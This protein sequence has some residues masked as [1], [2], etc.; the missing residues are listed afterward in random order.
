MV[1]S[2]LHQGSGRKGALTFHVPRIA[3]YIST[4]A[5][6]FD[7]WHS[8]LIE[9]AEV[10]Q[11]LFRSPIP[12]NRGVFSLALIYPYIGALDL[13]STTQGATP[14]ARDTNRGGR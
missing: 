12:H 5:H 11:P 14:E 10:Y 13:L 3:I 7:N 4:V 6:V 8:L 2:R 9:S 1:V